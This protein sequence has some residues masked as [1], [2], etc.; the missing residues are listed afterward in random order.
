MPLALALDLGTT[1][2]AAVAVEESGK[3]VAHSQAANPAAIG[4][5]SE[6]LA[7]QDPT[8]LRETSVRLLHQLAQDL[9]DAPHCLGVTGQM[10]GVLLL[11]GRRRPLTNL[12]TWQDGRANHTVPGTQHSWVDDYLAKCPEDAL[13][14]TGCRLSAG[15]L[16][17]TLYVLT[18]Q[19]A[20]P[21]EADWAA[22]AADW[23][24]MELGGGQAC[25]DRTNAAS[26][27]LYDLGRDAWSD[28]LIEAGSLLPELFPPVRDSGAVVG[29]LTSE[30]AEQT[31]LPPGL[32]VCNAV[33][34]NQAAVLGSIPAGDPAIQINIGT[35]GQINWPMDAFRRVQGME[36]RPFPHGR[37]LLVGAGLAGGDAY[38][39]VNRTIGSWLEAFGVAMPTDEIYERMNELAAGVPEETDGLKCEPFFRGTRQHPEACGSFR[40][41]TVDNFTIGH[42]ARAIVQGIAG[43]IYWFYDQAGAAQPR[44]LS[45]IIGSGH[46]LRKNRLLAESIGRLF[47]R[48]VW[49]TTH[50]EEAAYGA[51]LLAGAATGLWPDL[52]TAGRHIRLQSVFRRSE[53]SL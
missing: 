13:E 5:L 53:A 26:S 30:M 2:L 16:G 12:I 20:L 45:R 37:F 52:E 31:G 33:G 43:G 40:G 32:P 36:T 9:P 7:E 8:R 10:H 1:S 15:Y 4:G 48:D 21:P 22:F 19:G 34:D 17:A 18:H 49:L 27:G 23:L 25:T 50:N 39:W 14:R 35:G 42:V 28:E 41:V 38:A 24:A 44:H 11:D 3:I 47:D 6:G 46:G 29:Q 51:A